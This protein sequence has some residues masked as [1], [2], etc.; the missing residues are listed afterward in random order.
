MVD[1]KIEKMITGDVLTASEAYQNVVHLCDEYGSRFAGTEGSKQAVDFIAHK[2]REYGL[3]NVKE[4][5]FTYM[6]W[7]PGEVKL[8]I[9]EP[10]SA[11]L[12]AFPMVYSPATNPEGCEGEL[13]ILSEAT[14]EEFKERKDE[15]KGKFVMMKGHAR[16][17]KYTRYATYTRTVQAGGKGFII[18]L[19]Q[20]GQLAGTGSVRP[21]MMGEIPSVCISKETG[22]YLTRMAEKSPVRLRI[23]ANHRSLPDST[24]WNIVGDIRGSTFPDEHIIVGAHH[25]GHFIG[26]G[27]LDCGTP[28]GILLDIARVLM[29]HKGHLKRTVRFVFFGAEELGCAGS[30]AYVKA[31]REELGNV[32]AMINT[33]GAARYGR[34]SLRVYGNENL[35]DYLKGLGDILSRPDL[36]NMVK[37]SPSMSTGGDQ[38]PFILAGVPAISMG[39]TIPPSQRTSMVSWDHTKADTVDKVNNEFILQDQVL[40]SRIL[41]RMANEDKRVAGF[42][43]K[44][45]VV[46]EI[47][48]I[49]LADELRMQRKYL[50]PGMEH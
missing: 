23:T 35:Y 36:V 48:A 6:G 25:D 5:P 12:E 32:Y 7:A 33:D 40:L 30:V 1:L 37:F 17:G 24:T 16:G 29:K 10:Q 22:A 44:D 28:T 34:S 50:V 18:C 41:L 47:E 9:I 49:G 4:E 39:S 46:Q 26:K 8:G 11:E 19:W 13:L 31:H 15:I 38:W 2:L 20:P 14:P 27:A 45:D 42:S 43:D 3:E 21:R